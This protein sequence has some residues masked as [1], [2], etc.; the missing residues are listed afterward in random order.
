MLWCSGCSRGSAC[1]IVVIG[2]GGVDGPGHLHADG[3][4]LAVDHGGWA[5]CNTSWPSGAL[6]PAGPARE[7]PSM[8]RSPAV[9]II[10]AVPDAAGRVRHDDHDCGGPPHRGSL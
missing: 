1:W 3:A 4:A 7:T 9:V 6:P 10:V 2:W 5:G 8:W